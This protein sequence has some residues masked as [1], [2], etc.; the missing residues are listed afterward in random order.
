MEIAKIPVSDRLANGSF[1]IDEKTDGEVFA[2]YE[3]KQW[4]EQ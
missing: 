2:V 4:D 3:T 1:A